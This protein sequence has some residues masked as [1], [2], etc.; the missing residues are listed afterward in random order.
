MPID[1]LL[2]KVIIKYWRGIDNLELDLRPGFPS[3]LIGTNN[4]GKTAALDAIALALA[5]A[6]FGGQWSPDEDD[7][8][9][10]QQG[11]R[12]GEFI[13]QVLF[14][15]KDEAG[16]PAVRG[17]GK[18][19]SVHGVQVRGT[20]KDGKAKHQRTLLDEKLQPILIAPRT[21][22]SAEDKVKWKE[23]GVNWTQY[24]ARL[25]EISEH[26]PEVWLFR[27]QEIEA[28]LYIWKRGPIARLSRLLAQ[29][30]LADKWSIDR[31][32]GKKTQMPD[33]LH[34]A[35]A[36]FREAVEKFPFWRDDMK[37]K[38]EEAIARYVGSKAK[39]DL[40]PDVQVFEEWI[41]QQLAVSLATDPAGVVTPLSSM[42][43]G[44]QS[45][46]RLAALEALSQYPSQMRERVVVL[47]EEP[48][49]HLHPHLRRKLRKVLGDLSKNGWTVMYSTHAPE[50]VSFD[51][52][53]VITRLV[54]VGGSLISNC[55][56][57]DAIAAS[58]KLQSKLDERGAHDF[59][60]SSGTVFVE[61]RDDGFACRYTFD[62][63]DVDIDGLSISITQ[64]NAVS[65][66]RAFAAIAKELGIR[67]CAL[68]DEDRQT[69]GGVNPTT[70]AERRRIEKL[71]Q[72]AD[73]QVQWP[74]KLEAC[75]GIVAPNKALPE[76]TEPL[77][78]HPDWR[79]NHP[80]YYATVASI[81]A[82][83]DPALKI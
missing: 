27:P 50:M 58:A 81:A 14:E 51:A 24:Y 47:L 62:A 76:T 65:V 1:Y 21:A 55:V 41:A 75:L 3:V 83:I 20:L 57:T 30:F 77:L 7:F 48:E 56:H 72:E 6:A 29:R 17:V 59:L 31:D 69:T 19:I 40:R 25:D 23:H 82:W 34:K 64:C 70:E 8:Y 67:W 28:S 9:C 38:L 32:D 46:V 36:F 45:I 26:I 52:D 53:Q 42:G 35:H 44:W 43:D 13:I 5:S 79:T 11:R 16:Y 39:V 18:P 73:I 66:I 37:P 12:S 22:L 2:S 49:T 4:A 33:T 63:T 54:R 74:G 61:G 60:F 80:E 78:R 71:R 68:T 15:A 10:D